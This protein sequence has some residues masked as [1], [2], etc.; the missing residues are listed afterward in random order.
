MVE[1]ALE[2]IRRD[3]HARRV[4]I[5][6]HVMFIALDQRERPASVVAH[7][8]REDALDVARGNAAIQLANASPRRTD[9]GSVV[10]GRFDAIVSNCRTS[11][12]DDQHCGV[13]RHPF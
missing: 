5:S 9:C 11:R 1:L 4:L 3:A 6:A 10:D 7:R 8:H 12:P 2:S 13:W